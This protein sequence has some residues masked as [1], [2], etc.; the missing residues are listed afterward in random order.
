MTFIHAKNVVVSLAANDLTAYTNK[1]DL[2]RE[3]DSHDVTAF[4]QNSKNYAGGLLDGKFQ[5]EGTYDDGAG[6]PQAVIEPL[7]GTVVVLVYKP[8]GT[9]S[10]KPIKTVS[11]LVMKYKE[12]SEVAGMI[13]WT[14]ELQCTG[15][16]ALTS[17]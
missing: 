16:I 9:G 15:D 17:G 6:G 1:C 5:L 7:L 14:A 13:K 4:G 3:S 11:V 12:S 8:E 2:D 10:G